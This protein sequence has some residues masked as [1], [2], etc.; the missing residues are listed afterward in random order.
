MKRLLISTLLLTVSLFAQSA[1][2]IIQDNGCLACHAVASKKAAPAFAGIGMRNKRFEG[3]N[4]KEVIMA[5]IKNGS[6]GKYPRFSNSAMPA[7]ANLTQDQLNT[8]ADYILAQ[9]SKARGMGKGGGMGRG[10]GM[11]MGGGM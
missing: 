11:G 3:E 8:V 10:Q 2:E 4:A 1:E 6:Q 9:S 7:F 5:S